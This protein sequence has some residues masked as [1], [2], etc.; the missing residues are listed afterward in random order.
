M[1]GHVYSHSIGYAGS[2]YQ[3]FTTNY[4]LNGSYRYFDATVGIDAAN[5]S[6]TQVEFTISGNPGGGSMKKLKD[7]SASWASP[8]SIHLPVNGVTQLTLDTNSGEACLDVEFVWGDA[9]LTP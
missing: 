6:G 1:L 8:A 3:E 5:Q 7:V 2:C 9:R 4:D